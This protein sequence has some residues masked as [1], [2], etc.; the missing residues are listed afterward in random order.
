MIM[1]EI[2]EIALYCLLALV[3]IV[4]VLYVFS[5]GFLNS[6]YDVHVSLSQTSHNVTYPYQTLHYLVNITN[7]G[8]NQVNNLLVAVYLNNVQQSS[9][10]ISIP[11][12]Q[13]VVMLENYTYPAPGPY[14]LDVVADPGHI[15]EVK[16]RTSA[17]NTL[18]TNVTSPTLPDVYTSIPNT[19]ISNTQSFTFTEAGIIGSSAIAQRYNL[20]LVNR[21]FGPG[22][23]ISAKVFENI[24]PFTANIYGAWAEYNDNSTAYTA[25]LQGTTNPEII[26]AVISSFGTTVQNMSYGGGSLGFAAINKTTSMCTFY[27]DGWTKIISYYNNSGPGTCITIARSSY[28]SNESTVLLNAVKNNKNLTHFQ[29]GFFYLNSS[30]LGSALSYANNNITTTNLFENNYGVFISSIKRLGSGINVS[31]ANNSTCYGLIYN[32]NST[33][34]CSYFIAPRNGNYTLP[35]AMINSSYLTSNYIINIYSLVN[36]T[37]LVSAHDNAAHLIS[38]L[39]VNENSVVWNPV[40][41]N[42]CMFDNQSIGCTFDQFSKAN[43]TAYFN[44]TNGLPDA[45]RVNQLNCEEGAGFKNTTVNET[46][47]PHS[48]KLFI[49]SCSVLPVPV[50]SIVINFM[51]LLNY[52]YNNSTRMLNGTL[53][54]SNQV[55]V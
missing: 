36:N 44:I 49:Q 25:W 50:S 16:N 38:L 55:P 4:A 15:L 18:I 40:F 13:S 12:R 2:K 53:N 45:L 1:P 31:A 35:F 54:V 22:E 7:K 3:V 19:N 11:P 47:A 10:T 28:A 9:K 37:Q 41:K 5:N 27:S 14:E 6:S 43:D 23:G 17:Q 52:T 29:S 24:Y 26:G 34:I 33:N 8:N 20:S 46:I 21:F 42:S 39:G 30:V 48:S 51:L 32:S